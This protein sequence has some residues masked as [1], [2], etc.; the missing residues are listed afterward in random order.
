[1]GY[2]RQRICEIQFRNRGLFHT[3]YRPRPRF[4]WSLCYPVIR[5]VRYDAGLLTEKTLVRL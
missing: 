1:M 5:S 2:D 3:N 4:Q